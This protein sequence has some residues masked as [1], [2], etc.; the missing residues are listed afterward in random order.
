MNRKYDLARQSVPRRLKA[1]DAETY[2]N[3]SED[4]HTLEAC[5][6]T[7]SDSIEDI[8]HMLQNGLTHTPRSSL[9]FGPRACI[10]R[11]HHHI[12][13]GNVCA[14]QCDGRRPHGFAVVQ[15]P[16]QIAE[17]LEYSRV[18]SLVRC[19]RTHRRGQ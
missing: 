13:H 14:S 1:D 6:W 9:K 16:L 7:L 19:T 11:L 15:T 18:A 12:S 17:M 10:K 2:F 5:T 4:G 8:K 3:G